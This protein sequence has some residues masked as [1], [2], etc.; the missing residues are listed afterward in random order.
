MEIYLI[1]HGHTDPSKE[2]YDAALGTMNPPLTDKGVRQAALTAER[3]AGIGA[4]AI[5]SSDLKRT[6]STAEIIKRRVDVPVITSP[7]LREIEFGDVTL[8]PWS[9]FPEI[10]E[11]WKK[12]ER[13]IPYPGGENGAD[14]WRR[15]KKGLEDITSRQYE[16]VILVCHGGVIRA[17]VC[18]MLGIPQQTRFSLGS[19][20]ANCSITVIKYDSEGYVLHS[21]NDYAH[22]G[23]E[24]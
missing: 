9:D 3:L 6:V 22:L 7:L 24:I 17:I 20:V 5:Y 11:D 23:N 19:P 12:H 13:D 2:H 16:R 18:G 4:E 8:R 10:Y 21:F 1:R 14:V 15:C